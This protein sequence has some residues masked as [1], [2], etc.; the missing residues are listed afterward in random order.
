M[1]VPLSASEAGPEV[2][3]TAGLSRM[4]EFFER[5]SSSEVVSTVSGGADWVVAAQDQVEELE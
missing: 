2:A 3:K 5:L 1:A 4:A